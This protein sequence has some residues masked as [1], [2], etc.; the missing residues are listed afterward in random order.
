MNAVLFGVVTDVYDD[1]QMVRIEYRA[2]C[3]CHSG[4]ADPTREEGYAE[5][6]VAPDRIQNAPHM[7][8]TPTRHASVATIVVTDGSGRLSRTLTALDQQVYELASVVAVGSAKGVRAGAPGRSVAV[9]AT[10]R[11]AIDGVGPSIEYLWIVR[12]GAIPRPDALNAAVYDAIRTEAGMVGSKVVGEDG[13]LRSV[14]LVSDTFGVPYTGLD[15]FERDQGQ[16]DV[17]RDVAALSGVAL[18]LRRDLLHGLGGVDSSLAPGAAAIDLAQRARLRGARVVVSPASEVVFDQEARDDV[19]WREEA[20][21]IRAMMKAYSLLTLLWVIPL[22]FFIGLIEVIV[23]IFLGRWHGFE[24]AK[25]WGWNVI[26]LPSTLRARHQARSGRVAGDEQLFRFQRRGSVKIARLSSES[27]RALRSRLPGDER[28]SIEAVGQEMRQPAFVIGILAVLFVLVAARNLWSDGFPSVGYTLGFPSNGWD[29]LG[30]YAGGWN[31]AGLGSPDPLRPLLAIAGIAKV[32]TANAAALSEYLLGAGAMLSGIW[33]MM[34]LLRTWSISAAP[35]L[36]AGLVYVAGSAAQGIAGNTHIGTLLALGVLPWALRLTLRPVGEDGWAFAS[37]MAAVTL[38][39]G[40]LGAA[41][42]LLLLAPV[43]LIGAYALIRIT[44]GN[45]WRALILSLVGTAGGA[46][47]LSPWIWSADFVS[48][49]R[50]GYAYWPIPPIVGVAGVVVVVAAVVAARRH[51]GL[52][53]GWAGLLMSVGVLGARSGEFGF[54]TEF[55]SVA[56]AVLSLGA[57]IAVGIVAHAVADREGGGWRR[58]VMMVGVGGVTVLIA[59]SIVIMPG[60]RIGLP[61]DRFDSAFRFT[62]ATA[63]QAE[64]SRILVVGPSFLLPGDS[65]SIEGGAYRVV[66]APVPDLGEVRLAESLAFDDLLEEKLELIISGETR[67]AGGEL[68]LFG[69]RWIVVMGESSGPEAEEASV[70]WR[71]VFAGQLDLLPLTA[72]PENTVFVTDIQPV[73]RALTSAADAWPRI[74]WS[75][76]G[77]PAPGRRAFIAENP[78][79]G[80]GPPPRLTTESMNEISAETGVATY[81]PDP[82]SRTQAV[83]VLVAIMVLTGAAG[84]GRRRQ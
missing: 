42:P 29:A 69:I 18:L 51:L 45:A 10:L 35:G 83:F 14:G 81:T 63:G 70:A 21:R 56:L 3:P 68:A 62:L 49:A 48:M 44:D 60:G 59:V 57:A 34:R 53:A 20:G 2:K 47:L 43:P 78:D 64:Q 79:D 22:D 19:R 15:E 67:R 65:R 37:R 50:G 13:T 80:W 27:M 52:V 76:I 17:V 6:A 8:M 73:G 55:E 82:S 7:S 74:G 12:E 46:L 23:S 31:P 77:E 1:G 58:L 36:I 75:Y 24:F 30:A 4:A 26:Y 16:Y 25:S 72:A 38:T 66:S 9:H 40:L 39:F 61:G 11:E 5:L 33:G 71:N 54:G 28:F 41:S 32:V 84:W